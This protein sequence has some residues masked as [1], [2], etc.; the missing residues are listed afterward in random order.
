MNNDI[1][2]QSD[3]IYVE[4]STWENAHAHTSNLWPFMESKKFIS[5][6]LKDNDKELK[7]IS[8]LA[9]HSVSAL[10]LV[11]N[12]IEY[13]YQQCNNNTLSSLLRIMGAVPTI[14]LGIIVIILLNFFKFPMQ[15]SL[16]LWILLA[17]AI[18]LFY[19]EGLRLVSENKAKKYAF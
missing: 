18:I 11:A 14:L 5:E 13:K 6:I 1:K 8:A 12:V 16:G 19:R 4:L 9:K 2:K 10:A 3:E 15:Y 17:L 7:I